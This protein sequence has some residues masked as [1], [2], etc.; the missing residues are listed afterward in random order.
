MEFQKDIAWRLRMLYFG[1]A[2]FGLVILFQAFKVS[3][4]DREKWIQKN[5]EATLK[6]FTI[7]APRGNI[8][9]A[10]GG[11]L[12]T[13]VP[14]Y[15]LFIDLTVKPLTDELFNENIDSLGYCLASTFKD[16]SKEQYIKDFKNARKAKRE[17]Y[18]I[19]RGV[20]HNDF[21]KA[22]NFPIFRLGRY[23]GGFRYDQRNIRELPYR[24]IGKQT[25][26]KVVDSL[27]KTGIEGA[28]DE[29]LRGKEG[30]SLKRKLSGGQWKPVNDKYDV[31]PLDGYDVVSTIDIRMQDLTEHALLKQLIKHQAEGGCAILME[32]ETGHVKAIANLNRVKDTLYDEKQNDAIQRLSEP[33][34]TFKLMNMVALLE[35]G[36]V[37]LND[38]VDTKGGKV[39]VG[40][41]LIRDSH[42]GGYGKITVA[43]GFEVS[44]NT[45][46]AQVMHKVYKEKPELYID[47]L[48][49]MGLFQKLGIELPNE[50]A[51]KISTPGSKAW[52]KYSIPSMSMGYE[53]G[54]TPLQILTFYNAIANNGVMVRPLFAKEIKSKQRVI[55]K[56]EPQILNS[57]VCSELTLQKVKGLLEGVVENGTATNLKNTN[58]KIAGKTGT[59]TMFAKDEGG[60][61]DKNYQASFA[62][63]FPAANPKYS[64]IVVVYRPTTGGYY[65]NVVAGSVFKEIADKVFAQSLE[66]H[67][68]DID[69]Q[70]LSIAEMGFPAVKNGFTKDIKTLLEYFSLNVENENAGQWSAWKAGEEKPGIKNLP[71]T[72]KVVPNV[73]GMGLRDAI[74]LLEQA[75]LDVNVQGKGT[76]RRQSLIP[77][78]AITNNQTITI[79]LL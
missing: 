24:Y 37:K 55:K 18:L 28:Y 9:S 70:I 20:S 67:E 7:E 12:A 64:C 17:Y 60:Y 8:Y 35:D 25:I 45:V 5:E 4:V 39:M 43:R 68:D 46:I 49:K 36:L 38:T 66:L 23:K 77:G 69:T 78:Q 50:S 11:L 40:P 3:V 34:S 29:M 61:K 56:I 1:A 14:I 26:G 48:K 71:V 33:G 62:G 72:D 54:M 15:D 13:S 27:S 63:Y 10:D 42:E 59:A 57:S 52:S 22:K 79:E 6:L 47:R 65:G 75:G 41:K 31:E 53:V 76:V 19:K 16:K 21:I 2:I 32:V 30:K 51:P 74:F 73:K 58:Y 44:S